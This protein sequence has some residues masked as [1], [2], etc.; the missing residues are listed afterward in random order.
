M[1]M[2]ILWC[3]IYWWTQVRD[4]SQY[5]QQKFH[6]FCLCLCF[7]SPFVSLH[8]QSTHTLLH[9]LPSSSKPVRSMVCQVSS[10]VRPIFI[11]SVRWWIFAWLT[12]RARGTWVSVVVLLG[13]WIEAYTL[14][15]RLYVREHDCTHSNMR[16]FLSPLSPIYF[17]YLYK[18]CV[19]EGGECVLGTV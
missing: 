15:T 12:L 6:M 16:P 11:R 5:W 18:I 13:A 14:I 10:F 3:L 7:L 4:S 1:R 8:V 9:H 19:I 2:I 17:C